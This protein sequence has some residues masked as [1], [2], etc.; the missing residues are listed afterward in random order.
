M[1]FLEAGAEGGETTLFV[2]L[3]ETE[4]EL[5][6]KAASVGIDAETISFLDLR[7]DAPDADGRQETF[8]R[9]WTTRPSSAGSPS[10]S[11][12][13]IP[14]AWS[15]IRSPAFRISFRAENGTGKRSSVWVGISM[16]AAR[17]FCSPVA[18]TGTE[19]TSRSSKTGGANS[20]RASALGR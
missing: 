5:R 9:P 13:S 8:A 1:R 18:P 2:Y 4:V 12:R 6:K 7:A 3:S 10:A 16:T 11:P 19:T 20:E 17:R 14:T 15:S